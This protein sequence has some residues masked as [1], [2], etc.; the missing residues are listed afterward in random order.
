LVVIEDQLFNSTYVLERIAYKVMT[1][2]LVVDRGGTGDRDPPAGPDRR[3]EAS[4]ERPGR[5]EVG[6]GH[7]D[8]DREAR[9]GHGEGK[10]QQQDQPGPCVCV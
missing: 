6:A 1:I 4:A 10:P 8:D 7:P 5:G 9:L 3:P 2:L